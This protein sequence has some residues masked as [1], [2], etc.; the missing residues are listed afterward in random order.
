MALAQSPEDPTP[1]LNALLQAVR[2]AHSAT[3]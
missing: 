3:P 1:A 2:P